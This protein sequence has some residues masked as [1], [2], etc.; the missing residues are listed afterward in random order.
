V[1]VQF[2]VCD[3]LELNLRRFVCNF[4]ADAQVPADIHIEPVVLRENQASPVVSA[5]STSVHSTVKVNVTIDN[6]NMQ[7]FNGDSDLVSSAFSFA[8]LARSPRCW[9]CAVNNFETLKVGRQSGM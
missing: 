2:H 3:C 4:I 8:V 1:T 6:I 5:P 7:L 9:L